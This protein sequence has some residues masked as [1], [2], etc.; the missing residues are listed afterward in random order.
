MKYLTLIRHAKSSWD[1]ASQQDHDRTLNERGLRN[2]P[3]VGRFLAK[4]YF[5]A[6]G[7][8]AVLAKPD[9]LISSTAIRA[10]TTADIF[11]TEVKAAPPLLD[12]KLYLAAPGTLLQTVR[13]FDDK[14]KHVMIFGH[15]PGISEFAERLLARGDIE[16]MPTCTAV[17]I[18]LP[19][20]V[21]S[22]TDWN[23]G[24]LVGYVTPKLIEKR[25]A[26]DAKL[27]A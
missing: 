15:N 21:W 2:A 20:D 17:I 22:A 4:T 11:A 27:T 18:E 3:V 25:F 7:T 14:W 16:E 12:R 10:K 1:D 5:G 19:W 6:N 24:R 23:E 26:D 9:I 8:P 13:A